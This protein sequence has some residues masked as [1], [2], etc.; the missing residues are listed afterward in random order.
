MKSDSH[1]AG[2]YLKSLISRGESRHLDFKFEISDARKI[3][4][5]FSAFANTEGGKLLIGVKDNGR[6]SGVRSE[7]E[8]YMAEAAARMYCRPE[9]PFSVKRWF[10]EGKHVLE[11][12]IPESAQKPH[13]A[14][15][16]DDKWIAWVRVADENIRANRILV[17]YWKRS[18]EGAT[19]VNYGKAEKVL[20][21]YL[22]EHGRVT[23]SRF[24]RLSRTGMQE[25]GD[26]LVNLLLLK[27]ID[28]E[29]TSGGVF[30][31]LAGDSRTAR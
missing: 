24:M 25:A 13:F 19:M 15:N 29:L 23:L 26:I 20:M 21:E 16:D 3:A 6:I 28:M 8:L 11:I 17:D 22:A 4:R 5:T 9:V 10:V 2:L 12:D 27:V 18:R 1:S 14:R 7:E 30:Y 31:T